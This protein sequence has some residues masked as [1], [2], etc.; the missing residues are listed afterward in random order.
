MEAVLETFV[1]RQHK[2]T[3][4]YASSPIP[5]ISHTYIVQDFVCFHQLLGFQFLIVTDTNPW[6]ALGW[7]IT[8]GTLVDLFHIFLRETAYDLENKCLIYNYTGLCQSL[9]KAWLH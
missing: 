4:D 1:D 6:K 2:K 5:C 9:C 3:S 7:N 8:I